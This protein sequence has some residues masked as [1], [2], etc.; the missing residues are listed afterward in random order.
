MLIGLIIVAAVY[1][2]TFIVFRKQLWDWVHTNPSFLKSLAVGLA[3]TIPAAV[4]GMV[5]YT[6][7]KQDP[8]PAMP[9]NSGLSGVLDSLD[10]L[11]DSL[12]D[13]ITEVHNNKNTHRLK[14][15]E[16]QD[17]AASAGSISDLDIILHKSRKGR[18]TT[19]IPP[20]PP[21]PYG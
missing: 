15:K 7:N 3:F 2:V 6:I 21:N 17:E 12:D 11:S 10:E 13:Q 9:V 18:R 19:G 5:M 20:V 8:E 4:Y 1:V 16:Y 14:T